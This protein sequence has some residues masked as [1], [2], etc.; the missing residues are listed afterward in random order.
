MP[1]EEIN[2]T[3]APEIH[4][5][6]FQVESGNT[7]T[8]SIEM[9]VSSETPVTRMLSGVEGVKNPRPFAVEMNTMPIEKT[10]VP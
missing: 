7:E 8:R 1:S 3:E 5:R 9:S 10:S 2:N 4:Y 6:Y